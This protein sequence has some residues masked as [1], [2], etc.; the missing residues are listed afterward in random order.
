[1]VTNLRICNAN[2][3]HNFSRAAVFIFS[4]SYSLENQFE[5]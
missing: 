2:A 5:P 4:Y 3:E 1:L